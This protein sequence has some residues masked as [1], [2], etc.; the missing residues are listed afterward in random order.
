MNGILTNNQETR[1]KFPGEN[2]RE[3]YNFPVQILWH[4]GAN[5]HELFKLKEDMVNLH[6]LN[7]LYLLIFI[8]G[9]AANLPTPS[10]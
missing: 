3:T 4:R 6:I 2:K 8:S 7:M 10:L 9:H 1:E 5:V